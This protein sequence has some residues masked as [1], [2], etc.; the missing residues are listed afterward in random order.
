[1]R[2]FLPL[3]SYKVPILNEQHNRPT[4]Y[5]KKLEN[6]A[7]PSGYGNSA[8]FIASEEQKQLQNTIK[9]VQ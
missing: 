9:S 3:Q 1:M 8:L 2:R 6:R 4:N 7:Q 5:D